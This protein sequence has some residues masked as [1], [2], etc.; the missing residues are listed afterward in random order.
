[1]PEKP[2]VAVAVPSKSGASE[3]G[4]Q[5][6]TPCISAIGYVGQPGRASDAAKA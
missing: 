6:S 1:M 5:K 2:T 4:R 3:E